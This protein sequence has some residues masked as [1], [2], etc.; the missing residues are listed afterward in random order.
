MLRSNDLIWSRV[1]RPYLLGELARQLGAAALLVAAAVTGL[2][3]LLG[4]DLTEMVMTAFF[5][6]RNGARRPARGGHDHTCTWG[7]CNGAPEQ[8]MIPPDI[9]QLTG[10]VCA[11]RM[12][13]CLQR[14]CK[15]RF[16]AAMPV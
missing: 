4:R 16:I 5:V 8:A 14:F 12:I 15:L 2:G 13:L 11:Q 7:R 6:C 3:L 10:H 1:I 9:S